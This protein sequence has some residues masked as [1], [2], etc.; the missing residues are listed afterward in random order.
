MTTAGTPEPGARPAGPVLPAPEHGGSRSGRRGRPGRGARLLLAPI[1]LYQ[2]AISPRRMPTC[3]YF[4]TCSEYAVEAITRHGA[5]R[6]GWLALRR[7]LRCHPFHRGGHDPVP[8][9]V[10]PRSARSSQTSTRTPQE[11]PVA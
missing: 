11:P 4:P 9:T 2:L 7:I 1:R 5:A 3:R 6:G 10:G 8:D